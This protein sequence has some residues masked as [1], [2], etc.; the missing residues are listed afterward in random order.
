MRRSPTGP[1][2]GNVLRDWIGHDQ[3]FAVIGNNGAGRVRGAEDQALLIE[4]FG[5]RR[6]GAGCPSADA[7]HRQSIGEALLCDQTANRMALLLVRFEEL[8]T[9]C[10]RQHCGKFP[11]Q[12]V[13]VLDAGVQPETAGGRRAPARKM[14]PLRYVAA[15]WADAV[16]GTTPRTLT[17]RSGMPAA[18][19]MRSAERSGV[20]ASI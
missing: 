9:R 16:H 12:I 7:T 8:I 3:R 17:S 1:P 13:D 10:A 20:K 2:R 15:T 14:R 4:I 11:S 5:T 18:I 6:N 19:R